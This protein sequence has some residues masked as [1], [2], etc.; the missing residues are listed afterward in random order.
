MRTTFTITY[1]HA[2]QC[3]SHLCTYEKLQRPLHEGQQG[4]HASMATPALIL[5]ISTTT[6]VTVHSH[7]WQ[8]INQ[9]LPG[10]GLSD[11]V[12]LGH[13]HPHEKHSVQSMKC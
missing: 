13:T 3:I 9:P 7:I 12:E 10:V 1:L 8:G 2:G 6:E 5:L 11:E 4:I